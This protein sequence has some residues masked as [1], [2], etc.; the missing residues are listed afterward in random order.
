MDNNPSA[1]RSTWRVFVQGTLSC[2]ARMWKRGGK[3]TAGLPT[4]HMG[5]IRGDPQSIASIDASKLLCISRSF[6]FWNSG[7]FQ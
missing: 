4:F 3:S 2:T 1:C 6:K 7:L 5:P